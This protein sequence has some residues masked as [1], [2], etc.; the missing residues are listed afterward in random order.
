MEADRTHKQSSSCVWCWGWPTPFCVCV[1]VSE[2]E[3]ECQLTETVQLLR[4]L[5]RGTEAETQRAAHRSRSETNRESHNGISRDG[6]DL[7]LSRDEK[8]VGGIPSL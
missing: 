1:C 6:T 8:N 7:P 4:L 2:D 5:M 3:Q